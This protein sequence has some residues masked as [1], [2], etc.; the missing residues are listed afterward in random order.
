MM[1]LQGQVALVTGASRGIGRAIALAL[2]R[3]GAT[4]VG[5]ATTEAGAQAI[6]AAFEAA[7]IKGE[8]RVLDVARA[9]TDRCADRGDRE[10]ARRRSASW[11]TTPA[12]R[13]TTSCCA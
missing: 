6:T 11:S 8:G 13:A 3:H 10:G 4:V 2:G 12:S 1:S 9:A 5:T 7:G